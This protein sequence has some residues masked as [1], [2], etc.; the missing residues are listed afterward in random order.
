MDPMRNAC[1]QQRRVFR[2]EVARSD[3]YTFFNLR[4]EDELFDQVEALLPAHRE[5]LLPPTEVLSMFQ[6][7]ALSADRSCRKAVNDLAA[8]RAAGGLSTC[9]VPTAELGSGCRNPWCRRLC[10][11]VVA[12]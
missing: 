9:S 3:A 6:A 12:R 4:T 11:T 10:G 2:R 1:A 5:R 7:Q 8:R